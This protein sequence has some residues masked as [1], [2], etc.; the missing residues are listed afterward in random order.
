[1]SNNGSTHNL[2]S[3]SSSMTVD[4]ILRDLY[5]DN[6]AVATEN[7]LLDAEVA[8]VYDAD[9]NSSVTDCEGSNGERGISKTDDVWREIAAGRSERN[10]GK[11]EA[12]QEM[13][14]LEDFL[15]KAV[16]VEKDVK[17][18]V[19]GPMQERLSGGFFAFDPIGQ[20]QFARQTMVEHS[21]LEFENE[22]DAIRGVGRGKRRRG[23]VVEALD[24]AAQQM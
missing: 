6:P 8:L 2:A 20:S 13:M 7:T 21:V 24:K 19:S 10:D 4:E 5:G 11:M 3:S 18:P 17:A 12:P 22:V 9:A 14:T 15:A 16:A 23:P 1:M